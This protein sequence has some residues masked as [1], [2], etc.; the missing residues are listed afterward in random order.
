MNTKA[1]SLREREALLFVNV[2]V[3]DQHISGKVGKCTLGD[4]H[5]DVRGVASEKGEAD[6]VRRTI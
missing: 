6:M 1:V 2:V 5:I 4:R 3:L